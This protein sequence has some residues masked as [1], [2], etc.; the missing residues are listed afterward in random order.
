[1]MMKRAT[2]LPFT[3]T[4]K[5]P[6]TLQTTNFHPKPQLLLPNNSI[7]KTASFLSFTLSLA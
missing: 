7:S 5:F 2:F 3:I 1:M 6:S 4:S